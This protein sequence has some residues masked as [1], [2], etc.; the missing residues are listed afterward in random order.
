MGV[1]ASKPPTPGGQ[2]LGSSPGP[3]PA[4]DS[5]VFEAASVLQST[6]IDPLT[7]PV[8]VLVQWGSVRMIVAVN[9]P[10]N[11]GNRYRLNDRDGI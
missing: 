7:R 5:E 4:T 10:V 1:G 6:T 8:S 2:I 11:S 9:V 3:S